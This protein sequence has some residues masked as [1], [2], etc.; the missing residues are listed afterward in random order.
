MLGLSMYQLSE[1]KETACLKCRASFITL[2][3]INTK[4]KIDF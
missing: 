4:Q 1:K 2:L 3:V